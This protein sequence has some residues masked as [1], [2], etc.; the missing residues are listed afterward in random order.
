MNILDTTPSWA[1][2]VSAIALASVLGLSW[3]LSFTTG[4]IVGRRVW[5]EYLG[6]TV[7]VFLIVIDSHDV[8][9]GMMGGGGGDPP[10]VGDALRACAYAVYL[11]AR[12]VNMRR[13]ARRLVTTVATSIARGALEERGQASRR[14]TDRP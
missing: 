9:A 10:S 5:F 14:R 8:W 6:L 7:V 1:G 4:R 13:Y 11:V 12:V 2:W 3:G